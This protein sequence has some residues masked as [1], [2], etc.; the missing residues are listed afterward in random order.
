MV[1]PFICLIWAL[2]AVSVCPAWTRPCLPQFGIQP[3]GGGVLFAGAFGL[4]ITSFAG[5][6]KIF[7]TEGRLFGRGSRSAAKHGGGRACR[8]LDQSRSVWSARASAPL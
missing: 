5:A 3:I 2:R 1:V 8:W 4:S 7:Q 6:E